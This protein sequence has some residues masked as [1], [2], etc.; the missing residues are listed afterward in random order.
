MV[1][2]QNDTILLRGIG[3]GNWLLPEGYMW[4]FGESGDRP[5]K[6]E[7]IVEDLTSP[8]F[9]QKFWKEFRLNYITEADIKKIK[10]LGFNS[11]RP[12]LNA[13]VFMTEGDTAVFIEENFAILDSLI[14]WCGKHKLY[15]ILDM[16]GAPGGQTGQNIDDSP[17]NEP[18][19]FMDPKFEH[20]LTR[21][22]LKLVERY[23]DNP[24]VAAYDL[25]NEPLPENTGAA[26]KY[27]HLLLPMYK[28]LTTE[29]RKIDQKHMIILEGY[30]WSNNWS[31]FTET[32]DNNLVYQFH[33]YCWGNPDHLNDISHYIKE[34][35]RLNAP[36]WVGE[37]GE[38]NPAIY[39]ATTQYFEKNNIGWA[40]WPWK[41]IDN[42]QVVYSVKAPDGYDK[43][44][45]Y[46]RGG[47]KPSKE[48][49]EQ[50][51]NQLLEN[52]KV[53]NCDFLEHITQ[54]MLRQVPAKIYAV[55]Y[56]HDG[57]GISYSVN[58][59][60]KAQFYRTNEPVKTVLMPEEPEQ[61]R[62]NQEIA[63]VLNEGENTSYTVFGAD[64][65]QATITIKAKANTANSV[66]KL[67]INDLTTEIQAADTTWNEFVFDNA[68]VK[69]GK[70]ILKTEVTTGNISFLHFD[71]KRK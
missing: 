57:E 34:R 66:F 37:T 25:L 12:A 2:E 3:L 50:V 20:R 32:I 10:E 9:S 62:R 54:A 64:E 67:T 53:E 65:F 19:L 24:V 11:V 35:E 58:D 16:H 69:T 63:I 28:N 8:E 39:F 5:R 49:A 23:K 41:K 36:V 52:I 6:I 55:N 7:K 48:M 33:Y 27:K 51:F 40:F 45:E 38:R 46:S 14:D 29:I 70:N 47:E 1:N 60:A 4:H 22:W 61:R 26:E 31:I 59:T 56:G 68:Q 30:N 21:L 17:N 13:R 18:E 43:I 42:R 15:V 44:I 71:V